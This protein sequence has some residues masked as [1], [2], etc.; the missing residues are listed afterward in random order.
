MNIE[1]NDKIKVTKVNRNVEET[2]KGVVK[3]IYKTFIVANNGLY[4]FC[5][6]IAS[7][8]MNAFTLEI[9]SLICSSLEFFSDKIE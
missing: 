6:N 1:V 4:N 9:L 3:A 7:G 8:S 5:I 2:T